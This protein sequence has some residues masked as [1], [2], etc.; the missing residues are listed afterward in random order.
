MTEPK[1]QSLE[2]TPEDSAQLDEEI[3]PETLKRI[4]GGFGRS[5]YSSYSSSKSASYSSNSGSNNNSG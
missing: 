5:C 4:S 3:K 2:E 1:P